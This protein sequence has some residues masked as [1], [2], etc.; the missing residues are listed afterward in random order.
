[1]AKH[2]DKKLA[3]YRASKHGGGGE[4]FLSVF[5]FLLQQR[6]RKAGEV[7]LMTILQQLPPKGRA[8]KRG[9]G[10]RLGHVTRG[11]SLAKR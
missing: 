4:E 1:M 5:L 10:M 3:E 2:L 11:R 9:R 7:A 8:P 6:R